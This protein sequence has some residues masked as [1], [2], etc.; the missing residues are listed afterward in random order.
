MTH[1]AGLTFTVAACA[2]VTLVVLAHR[3]R[4]PSI[5][6]LLAGGVVLGPEVLGF[7]DPAALGA[8]LETVVSL[9]V[10]IILFEG[11][12]TLDVAGYRRA[13]AV[14]QR[15]LSWGVII[16]WLGMAGAV[17]L[18]MDLPIELAMLAG[19]LVVVTGPTVISPLLRRLSLP[20]RIHHALYWE[21]VLIDAVGVFIAVLCFEL[22]SAPE[23][24]SA[25]AAFGNLALR[26]LLGAAVGAIAG[27]V[28]GRLLRAEL[29]PDELA[30]IF[31]LTF[32]LMLFAASNA[33]MHE[34]GILAVVVAGLVVALHRPAQLVR[35]KHFKE[36]LTELG[37]GLLFILLSATLDLG[38]F[39]ELGWPLVGLL[40][41]VVFVLRPINIAVATAGQGFSIREKLFLSWIA[42]RGIVAASMASLFSLRLQE[43]G[44]PAAAVLE[45]I[46][47]AV[48][49]TTVALQGLSAPYVARA[50]GLE[51]RTRQGWLV[52]GG[53]PLG[54][55][56]ARALRRAG[57]PTVARDRSAVS[58]TVTL[59]RLADVG[60]I[61]TV[62]A[63]PTRRDQTMREWAARV[64]DDSCFRW[65]P[66]VAAE[67]SRVSTAQPHGVAVWSDLLAS[68]DHIAHAL[69]DGTLT[70]DVVDSGP[71]EEQG[72]FGPS[73]LPLIWVTDGHACVE[74]TPHQP[75]TDRGQLAIV[76]RKQISG[77]AGLI[78]GV[79]VADEAQASMSAVLLRLLVAVGHDHPEVDPEVLLAGIL[80]REQSLSTAVGGGVA[81]PHTYHDA[82]SEPR[83]Y[84]AH[85][86][87]GLSLAAPDGEPVHFVFLVISPSAAAQ[88]HLTSLAAIA[89]LSGDAGFMQ[90]LRRQWSPERIARLI[91]E[92]A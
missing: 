89:R 2:G 47:Y 23:G 79:E 27:I 16:T 18:L 14:I 31:V 69:D 82:V 35:L 85:V 81:I 38:R 65:E 42:P 20:E 61:L 9:T 41:V 75:G 26:V 58:D 84:V 74:P 34:S 68:S 86:V 30:N 12:L 64:G 39:A 15:M 43:E 48:I 91:S 77:L 19:S 78:A 87:S 22:I 29:L 25:D 7:I 72:R 88:A 3:L 66:P 40:A 32:V 46:T 44:H 53:H 5:V 49:A 6:L 51:R 4:V 33:I 70:L 92:R 56:L 52:S 11:G 1:D 54:A 13:P 60:Q 17:W 55:E 59:P 24:S 71:P 50:L 10:A 73:F 90:L 36:Q 57:V 80:E 67:G 83:C 8:G 37:I 62:D 28:S 45:T 21:G 63:D 76:L